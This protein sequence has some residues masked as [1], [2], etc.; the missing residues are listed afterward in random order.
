MKTTGEKIREL[1]NMIDMSQ[2]K[3]AEELGVALRTLQRYESDESDPDKFALTRL[4]TYFDVSADY[5]LGICDCE[6]QNSIS[7]KGTQNKLYHRYVELRNNHTID[8]GADYYWIRT[9]RGMIGGATKFVGWLDKPGGKQRRV[10]REIDAERAVEAW[11]EKYGKPVVL[12]NEDDVL[13]YFKF[14]GHALIR[15]DVC[16]KY[17]PWYLE[18]YFYIL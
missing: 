5:L 12:N 9:A 14:S 11:P 18:D 8:K 16:K 10:L 15:K 13:A 17:A 7:Q 4:A 1:R 6:M 3:L 2:N